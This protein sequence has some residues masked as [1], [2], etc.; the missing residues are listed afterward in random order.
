M[1]LLPFATQSVNRAEYSGER[2]V[3]YYARPVQGAAPV[4]LIGRM[5][6]QLVEGFAETQVRAIA[7]WKN[8]LVIVAGGRAYLFDP[9]NKTTTVLGPVNDHHRTTIAP[10]DRW[11]AIAAGGKY[12]ATLGVADDMRTPGPGALEAVNYVTYID[13]YF[14]LAGQ[15]G[16]RRDVI[17]VSKPDAANNF[18]ALDFA[19]AES[20]ADKITGLAADHGELWVFGSRS[21]EVWQNTGGTFPF[22]RAPGAQ[23]E[24]GCIDSPVIAKEDNAVF[25]VGPDNVVYRSAGS[26]PQVIS[27]RE[28]EECLAKHRVTNAFTFEEA[29]AKFY[30]VRVEGAPSHVYD[31]TTGLWHERATDLGPWIA[32]CGALALGKQFLGTRHGLLAEWSTRYRDIGEPVRAI[33]RSA[34]ISEDYWFRINRVHVNF[35]DGAGTAPQVIMAHT[36]DGRNW[37]APRMLPLA[38]E[39]KYWQRVARH[40]FGAVRRFQVELTVADDVQRDI[41]GVSYA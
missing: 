19:T 26:S 8:R 30:C 32:T 17:Q 31:M 33:A 1:P 27:T 35:S 25:W 14:V 20:D 23:M 12:Y 13:G 41:V 24:R 5:G 39:G 21:I 4:A 34:P 11:C 15:M 28:V 7:N 16:T 22:A 2:L 9:S 10:G 29:G 38:G 6:L 3:N 40:G 37:K 18:D 36:N